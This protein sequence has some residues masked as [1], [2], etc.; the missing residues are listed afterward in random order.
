MFRMKL[1]VLTQPIMYEHA[2]LTVVSDVT[3]L[4]YG[5]VSDDTRYRYGMVQSF[6]DISDKAYIAA[7]SLTPPVPHSAPTTLSKGMSQEFFLKDL[8]CQDED[9]C[10]EMQYFDLT[11]LQIATNNFSD[12]NKLGQGGFGPVYKGKLH[13]GKEIAI[14]RLSNN[15]GQGLEE[16]RIEVK[17]IV[18]LQ[19]RNIVRLLG[20]CIQKD[21]K[22]LVYEYMANTSLDAFL[23]DSTKCKELDWAKRENIVIG[24]VKGLLYLHEDSRLKIIHRDMK[25]NNVLLDDEMNPKISDFGTAKISYVN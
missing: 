1:K 3:H 21:E 7:S 11:T 4:G 9:D 10:R 12:A 14:K 22:L 19:H 17:L 8:E 2:E 25:A 20:C 15:S 23:F 24:I 5:M 18:K 16:F 13:D 6:R